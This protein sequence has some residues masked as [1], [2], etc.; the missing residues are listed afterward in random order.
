V[1]APLAISFVFKFEEWFQATRNGSD[2]AARKANDFWVRICQD[3]LI[4]EPVPAKNPI[5][6]RIFFA[7]NAGRKTESGIGGK[8]P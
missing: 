5:D 8:N 4:S 1:H 3:V 7:D 6:C 2:L